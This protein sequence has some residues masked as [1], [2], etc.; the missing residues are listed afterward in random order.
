MSEPS[1]K[2]L[3]IDYL[4]GSVTPFVL[5][6]EKGKKLTIVYGEN[7]SGKSTICD[8]FEFLGKGKV[9]SLESRGLG[10][11]NKYWHSIGRVPADVVVTLETANSTCLAKIVK[12]EVAVDPVAARPRVEVLR[13]SQILSLIEATPADRYAE[14]S[15]FI[16][17]SGVEAS[18]ATLRGLIRD[19]DGSRGVAIARIQENQDA[20]G[21]FWSSAGAPGTDALSWAKVEATRDP[22]E[23][24]K[25]L[26]ALAKLQAAYVRLGDY[27]ARL[28]TAE[29]AIQAAATAATAVQAKADEQ[30]QTI[31]KDAGEIVGVLEAARSYL[32]KHP[33]PQACPL[34]ESTEKVEGLSQRI[35]QRL[36]SF[37]ALQSTR[38]QVTAAGR[39]TQQVEHQL[40]ALR[41]SAKKH[42]EEF[43]QARTAFAWSS[44]IE[45]PP[46]LAPVDIVALAD[47]LAATANLIA[48]WKKAETARVDKKQF[49]KTLKGALKTYVENV[50]T[51]QELDILLPNLT[52]TL[53]IV[54]EERRSFSDSVL[55]KIAGEVGR[56]YEEVHP[57]EGLNKIS[58]ELDPSKRASLSIG[59]SFCGQAGAQPQAYFSDSHLDTL[60]LCVFLALAAM[61]GAESTILVLDDVLASVDEPHVERLIEILYAEALKFRH[62]VI[63]THYRPWKQKLRW[64]WL[65]NGQCQ[66]V[67]LNRW[68]SQAGMTL[69]ANL[70][71]VERLR[72]L[73]GDV[74][75]DPQSVCA[76]A[77]VILEAALDFLTQLYECSVPRRPNH[78]YTLGDLLPSI[79]KKL[80]ESLRVEVKTGVEANGT[81]IYESRSLTPILDELTRIAQARN[82]FGCHFN[83]LSF[84]FLDSDAVGFGQQ[85]L[86]LMDTLT[87]ADAGWP[88]SAK[89]G[90]YWATAGESRRLHPLKQPS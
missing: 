2:K 61:E 53:E 28:K 77:G 37:S 26:E 49:T 38:V 83:M 47:W 50:A 34:C 81:G 89:S 68:S 15:R 79:N 80:R 5:P 13:R 69:I 40:A 87:D 35:T 85:V 27:P 18:E 23:S 57:G 52:R 56:I 43:E 11:T 72:V 74:P 32:Q 36:G 12:S 33:D 30:L 44:D 14:V 8:A 51:Q 65:Q 46:A 73:L 64:G 76:K 6:F 63:T 75:P 3:T 66:F 58:L 60:G 24:D 21:Q 4:R 71:E 25:E 86:L 84:E 48:E 17:V 45:M 78:Q 31:A 59:A 90:S 55:A 1:L 22:N 82:I 39:N 20:I 88:R 67:E 29:V 42:A 19:M 10:K 70:P 62:C 7:A 9:G 16:D 41:D 54:Q